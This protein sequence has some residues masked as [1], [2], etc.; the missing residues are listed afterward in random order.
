MAKYS[1][2]FKIKLVPEYLDGNIG[3]GS[4]AKKYNM[5]SHTAIVAWV[6]A[7]K[8]QGMDGLK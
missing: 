8:S 2:G 5:D 7:Y 1:E 4:L 3:C 6:R